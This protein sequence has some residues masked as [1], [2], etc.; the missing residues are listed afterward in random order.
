MVQNRARKKIH[1]TIPP[2]L[3]DRVRLLVGRRGISSLT[4]ALL[5]N[6]CIAAEKEMSCNPI[7]EVENYPP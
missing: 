5:T 7:K 1:L 2:E 4:E 3:E 6:Y